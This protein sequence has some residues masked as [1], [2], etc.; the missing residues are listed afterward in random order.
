MK[1]FTKIISLFFIIFILL[2]INNV[3]AEELIDGTINSIDYEI[4][5]KNNSDI[6]VKELWEVTLDNSIDVINKEFEKNVKVKD[7]YVS[8]Y[9]SSGNKK[10]DFTKIEDTNLSA[11]TFSVIKTSNDNDKIMLKLERITDDKIYVLISYTIENQSK[12]YLDCAEI[13]VNLQ[14]GMFN[15]KTEEISGRVIFEKE[16]TSLED[17]NIW[18]HSNNNFEFTMKSIEKINFYIEG[19][20]NNE[21]IDLKIVCGTE[22]FD[23]VSEENVIQEEKKQSII[24][25]ENRYIAEKEAKNKNT[26]IVQMTIIIVVIV[27]IIA[28][29]IV[30]VIKLFKMCKCCKCD[31]EQEN[32]SEDIKVKNGENNDTKNDINNNEDNKNN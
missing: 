25:E 30:V 27:L 1:R 23:N 18:I 4:L 14:N 11:N 28:I 13:N 15:F 32:I 12:Y 20:N 24:D 16:L 5:I 29:I 7:V 10:S 6:E 21:A 26:L 9:D 31:K 19:N 2:G 17:I 3:F 8:E 22:L